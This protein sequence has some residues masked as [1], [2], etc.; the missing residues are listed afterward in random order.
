MDFVKNMIAG[1]SQ[2]D[3]AI[4]VVAATDGQMPQ[5]K[6]HIMLA[7]QLGLKKV[8]V[9]INKVKKSENQ[10]SLFMLYL[11]TFIIEF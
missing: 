8:V 10:F 2:M 5:T 9:F 6:E 7:Q 11:S 4:L 3:A 1:T